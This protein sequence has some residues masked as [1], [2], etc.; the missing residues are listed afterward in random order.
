[1]PAVACPW[2][3]FGLGSP[4]GLLAPTDGTT[5]SGWGGRREELDR[6]SPAGLPVVATSRGR[7]PSV[8]PAG[9]APVA[10][11]PGRANGRDELWAVRQT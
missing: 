2:T 1:M 7:R 3:G 5:N 6:R 8:A 9:V 4:P 10:A 11:W